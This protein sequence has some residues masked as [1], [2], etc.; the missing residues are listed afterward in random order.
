ML[1]KKVLQ[2]ILLTFLIS[3]SV[4]L[5]AY[6]LHITYGSILSLVV[7]AVCY[8]PAPA[9]AT[10]ILQKLVY[11]GTL[12]PYG[13]TLKNLSLRWLLI[14]TVGFAW[15]IVLGTFVVIGILGNVF[16]VALFGRV[17]FSEAAVLQ[18]ITIFTRGAFG[19]LPQDF[20]I[21]PVAT[22]LLSLVQGVIAGFTVNLPFTFGEELGW[23]GLLLRETQKSGFLRSNL[24]IGVVWGLWHAPL[25]VQGHNYAGHP[26]AGIFMMT[27][28]TTSLSFPMAYCRFKSRTILG[29]SALHGMFNPLGA[30]TALFVVGANPLFGFVAGVAGIAVTLLLT[31]GICIFDKEFIRNY[32]TFGN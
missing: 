4:A 18:Q 11:R 23:R 24:F 13:F 32:Q 8:M 20:P 16:G 31:V 3:W 6:L 21:P 5:A 27:L 30:L 9:F 1:S 22:F 14:T 10:L 28:F 2:F 19:D 12:T 15:F 7:I 26:V 17:D 25:I 29:P